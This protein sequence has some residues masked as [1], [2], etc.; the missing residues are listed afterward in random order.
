MHSSVDG[1]SSAKVWHG[2]EEVI[3]GTLHRILKPNFIQ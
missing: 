1:E 3:S 2:R